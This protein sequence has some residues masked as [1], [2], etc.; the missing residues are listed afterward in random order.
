MQ[1][2]YQATWSRE[3]L[4]SDAGQVPDEI[5]NP[6]RGPTNLSFTPSLLQEAGTAHKRIFHI[7]SYPYRTISRSSAQTWNVCNLFPHPLAAPPKLSEVK[8]LPPIIIK[9][10]EM[11]QHPPRYSH[12]P[13]QTGSNKRSTFL[14]LSPNGSHL[15]MNSNLVYVATR[16]TALIFNGSP[17]QAHHSQL[18]DSQT[19]IK[20]ARN[21]R[22]LLYCVC[23]VAGQNDESE[24]QGAGLRHSGSSDDRRS[25]CVCMCVWPGKDPIVVAAEKQL[26][27]SWVLTVHCIDLPGYQ[28]ETKNQVS[29]SR[30]PQVRLALVRGYDSG[31]C[32]VGVRYGQRRVGF[33]ASSAWV[34]HCW[35]A[36]FRSMTCLVAEWLF[37]FLSEGWGCECL[38]AMGEI[39]LQVRWSSDSLRASIQPYPAMQSFRRTLCQHFVGDG[40]GSCGHEWLA[41]GAA[42]MSASVTLQCASRVN[43]Q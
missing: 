25:V 3:F 43:T 22:K 32:F 21:P 33:P 39:L 6:Y 19:G 11:T 27:G 1:T 28:P 14:Y 20:Q 34:L 24:A 26:P 17:M 10:K 35:V 9:K 4:K 36:S 15:A 23:R 13:A 7:S 16:P 18:S 29:R 2:S 41:D 31:K 40:I 38:H 42:P 30:S 5:T 12:M 8:E 37:L